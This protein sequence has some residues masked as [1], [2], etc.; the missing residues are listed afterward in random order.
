MPRGLAALAVLEGG[1]LGEER[2]PVAQASSA[3]PRS[4][5]RTR[6]R[7]AEGGRTCR[8]RRG[9]HHARAIPCS[10]ASCLRSAR[11]LEKLAGPAAVRRSA[12]APRAARAERMPA[13]CASPPAL[14]CRALHEEGELRRRR[15]AKFGPEPTLGN[16]PSEMSRYLP[17][18]SSSIT[19]FTCAADAW[20]S[21]P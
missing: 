13:A 7:F 17:A 2:L 5:P 16:F 15:R 9:E 20:E 18:T 11:R 14:P 3:P 8:K 6:P 1:D 19:S 21:V 12:C 4:P 10:L